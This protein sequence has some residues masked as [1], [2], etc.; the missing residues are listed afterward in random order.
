VTW[1]SLR[2]SRTTPIMRH[3]HISLARQPGDDYPH[4]PVP[5]Q[6]QRGDGASH[7]GAGNITNGQRDATVAVNCCLG[8]TH[9]FGTNMYATHRFC[10]MPPTSPLPKWGQGLCRGR[11]HRW[12]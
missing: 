1:R 8:I 12:Q 5:I 10:A 4:Y 6:R 2:I 3:P 9:S 11:Q 7:Q